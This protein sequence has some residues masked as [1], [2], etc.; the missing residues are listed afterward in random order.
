M[1]IN[2]YKE[3]QFNLDLYIKHFFVSNIIIFMFVYGYFFRKKTEGKLV[4]RNIN[5]L[6]NK[7]VLG[8]RKGQDYN[9]AKFL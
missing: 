4:H 9:L 7:R 2:C 6:N 1:I 3:Y 8:S 5:Y